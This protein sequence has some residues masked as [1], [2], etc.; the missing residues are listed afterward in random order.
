MTLLTDFTGGLFLSPPADLIPEGST[1]SNRGISPTALGSFRTRFGSSQL[2]TL[3]SHSI[4]Y[5]ANTFYYGVS[6]S[7][8]RTAVEIITGLSGDRL[9]FAKCPPVAGITD[10]LFL[11]GGDTLY[12]VDSSGNESAWGF[13]AP[14]SDP[15]AAAAAGGALADGTYTYQITYK[16]STTGHRS[17]GNGTDVS[18]TTAGANNSVALTN[19]PDGSLV[20]SQIDKVEIWRTV[21]G[22]SVLFYLA[23][24]DA[25]TASYTDDGSVTLSSIEL[26]TDNDEPFSYFDDC[27]GPYN[28]SMFWITRAQSGQRGR[29]FY[30]PVGRCESMQGFI[31]ITSDDNPLQRIFRFQGQLGVIAES[32]IFLIGGD[33]PYISRE[34]P[35]CP[36]TIEPFSVSVTPFGVIY[37]ASDGLRIFDGNSSIL[38]A[39]GTVER[40]FRG[41]ALGDLLAFSTPLVSTFA[42][43]EYYISD[44]S[45]SLAV[46]A[47]GEFRDL[48]VGL[49]ALYYSEES[50]QIAATLSAKVVDFESAL[51]YTDAGTAISTIL[52]PPHINVA[53]SLKSMFHYLLLDIDT[54]SQNCT[55]SVVHDDSTTSIGTFFTASRVRFGIPIN[56]TLFNVAGIRLVASLSNDI[57]EIFGLTP[58]IKPY[59]SIP[60]DFNDLLQYIVLDINTNGESVIFNL[61]HDGTT[62]SIGQFSTATRRKVTLIPG[63]TGKEFSFTLTGSTLVNSVDIYS[64]SFEFS[65]LGVQQMI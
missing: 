27:L 44:G 45:Q 61:I 18:A 63:V 9:S 64:V 26:P 50:D 19:I 51:T 54:N 37:R 42:R 46:N 36:G 40:L 1:R 53:D 6:T 41:E 52:E 65:K 28:A 20:D 7:L 10:Y 25:G 4:S 21:V 60:F 8:Y 62:K 14:A 48:G 33:N 16:N 49:S 29:L 56:L 31:E 35:A 39:F 59:I 15:S 47:Q 11:A 30:S 55:L 38:I 34:V 12:K 43:D 17:N 58:T 2:S 23:Q 5:F 24:I 22:G 32:G 3:N 13:D 57:I